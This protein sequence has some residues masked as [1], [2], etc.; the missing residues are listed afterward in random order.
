M[1]CTFVHCFPFLTLYA[2]FFFQSLSNR[3]RTR[4][5]ADEFCAFWFLILINFNAKNDNHN[6]NYNNNLNCSL[7][8]HIHSPQMLSCCVFDTDLVSLLLTLKSW[9]NVIVIGI[10]VDDRIA[11]RVCSFGFIFIHRF[12]IFTCCSFFVLPPLSTS[13]WL[14]NYKFYVLFIL[15]YSSSSISFLDV[16]SDRTHTH[17]YMNTY[18]III[19]IV[20][21]IN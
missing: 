10:A 6:N 14:F 11:A 20:I 13:T 21:I 17:I 9:F 2:C 18:V 15:I 3:F 16:W 8:S 7:V 4:K 19:V 5:L 1:S 12:C